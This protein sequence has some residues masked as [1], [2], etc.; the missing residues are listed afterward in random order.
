MKFSQLETPTV[1]TCSRTAHKRIRHDGGSALL[2][3]SRSTTCVCLGVLLPSIPT[4]CRATPRTLQASSCPN[5][6]SCGRSNV[7]GPH[8][9]CVTFR[10]LAMDLSVLHFADSTLSLAGLCHSF[11]TVSPCIPW[12]LARLRRCTWS[13][14]WH[15]LW[16]DPRLRTNLTACRLC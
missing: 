12:K 3:L 14:L 2:F 7:L 10:P 5:Q 8:C 11:V 15:E 16:N 9:I 4:L 6:A 1:F 13:G